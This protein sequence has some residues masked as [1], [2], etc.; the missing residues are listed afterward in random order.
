MRIQGAD[1]PSFY[2]AKKP[3]PPKDEERR[4]L[5]PEKS[6]TNYHII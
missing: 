5:M 1:S 4:L 6:D 3:D 2:T